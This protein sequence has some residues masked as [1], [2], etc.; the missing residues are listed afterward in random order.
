MIEGQKD[1][2]DDPFVLNSDRE[3]DRNIMRSVGFMDERIEGHLEYP[4]EHSDELYGGPRSIHNETF[5]FRRL[6]RR[7]AAATS[8]ALSLLVPMLIMVLTKSILIHLLTVCISVLIFGGI[9]V[10]TLHESHSASDAW[11][12]TVS[13]AAVLVV[14]IGT[15]S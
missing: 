12:A 3:M 6:V 15:I 5:R 1:G 11:T 13:Y 2:D 8:G 10:Y 14:F 7:F 4:L 9:L